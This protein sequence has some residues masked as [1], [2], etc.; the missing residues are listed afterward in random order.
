MSC[1]ALLNVIADIA[2]VSKINNIGVVEN[3]SNVKSNS[4][5]KKSRR[6]WRCL[7]SFSNHE[8]KLLSRGLRFVPTPEKIDYWKLKQDSVNLEKIKD[9]K[10]II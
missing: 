7:T 6:L 4:T 3:N 8:I 5:T 1:E 2:D 9:S 10:C